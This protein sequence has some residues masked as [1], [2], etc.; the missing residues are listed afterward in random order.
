M[1]NCGLVSRVVVIREKVEEVKSLIE[2][3]NGITLAGVL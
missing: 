1:V 2:P 3:I